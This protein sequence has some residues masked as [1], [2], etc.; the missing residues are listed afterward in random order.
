MEVTRIFDILERYKQKFDKS[1]ALGGKKDGIWETYSVDEYVKYSNKVSYGLLALG[2]KKGDKIATISNNRPEWNFVDMG[3]LQIGAVH[4]P[5][6]P[7]I[8]NE[9]TEYILNH[10][11]AKMIIV[12]DKSLFEK[13]KPIVEKI[14]VIKNFYTFNEVEGATN[15]KQ[16]TD[17]GE[18]NEEKYK[19]ELAKIKE[20]VA[21]DDLATLIYTSGTTGMPKGVVLTH[22]NLVTNF[23]ETSYAHPLGYEHRALSFL[24]LCHIYER[25]LTYHFQYKGISIYY[26]ESM[27]KI[28]ENLKEIQPHIF[29]TVP[30]LLEKVYDKIIGK[31]KN[32]S[33]V[34]KVIFFWA[35]RLGN[36]YNV[37]SKHKYF[38][39]FKLKIARKLI[40]SKWIEALG[41]NVYAIIS[42]GAALQPRL[43]R[44]FWA[45]GVHLAQ[46]Y[47][48]TETSPVISVNHTEL[49]NIKFTTVGKKKRKK[50]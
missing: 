20:S 42:G 29:S 23:I 6:Y 7:T 5:I 26:A 28:T 33:Y 12:S 45:A 18:E 43:E 48:L 9:E 41:G 25:M 2:I 22:N 3:L 13:L 36:R 8:S 10:C 24:P 16:I 11:D 31:G 1:D 50:R 30:R 47:G 4:V 37:R 40:F 38:Y 19:G 15:W 44:I 17:L 32:L 46:G 27:G 35:V 39:N 21:K 34:K 14:N 49:P